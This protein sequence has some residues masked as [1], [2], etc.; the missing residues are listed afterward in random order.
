MAATKNLKLEYYNGE[1]NY[2]SPAEISTEAANR[3]R[4]RKLGHGA[5]E[6]IL[7]L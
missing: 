5:L 3:I 6:N 7:G 4:A 1:E 2:V